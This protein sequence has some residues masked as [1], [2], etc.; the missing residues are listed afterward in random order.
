[1]KKL[2]AILLALIIVI[3][4]PISTFA[5]G[6]KISGA[7]VNA[8]RGGTV[9][10]PVN[11][12]ENSGFWL[13]YVDVY[14]DSAVLTYEGCLNA[15]FADTKLS[16][17]KVSDNHLSLLIEY[18]PFAECTQTG[19]VANLQFSVADTAKAGYYGVTYTCESGR[20]SAY[21]NADPVRAPFTVQ[22]S[23]VCVTCAEHS[24]TAGDNGEVCSF[25]GST[26]NAD[27]IISDPNISTDV[28][29]P[30]IEPN[31]ITNPDTAGDNSSSESGESA[32]QPGDN[33]ND[34]GTKTP[35]T[36][37]IFIFAGVGAAVIIAATVVLVILRKKKQQ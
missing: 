23:A 2:S 20:A 28:I 15:D 5:F 19:T 37:V 21:N 3:S 36:L 22:S 30:T 29:N 4:L 7:T 1:M 34:D 32:G 18:E 12:T 8:T 17:I 27:G 26:K 10:V 9:T 16:P 25:C 13:M 24:F 6:G 35:N 31:P 33:S 11:I 14:F